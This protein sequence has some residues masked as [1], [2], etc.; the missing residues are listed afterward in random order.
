MDKV[1][2]EATRDV[3]KQLEAQ[4]KEERL[5]H[6]KVRDTLS[7]TRFGVALA[8][9]SLVFVCAVHTTERDWRGDYLECVQDR[10][11][12]MEKV[13]DTQ[14]KFDRLLDMCANICTDDALGRAVPMEAVTDWWKAT[15]AGGMRK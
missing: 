14:K 1:H 4:I 8:S 6:T 11:D 15:K 12:D 13:S 9:I 5:A 10:I 3:V 2:D 7:V